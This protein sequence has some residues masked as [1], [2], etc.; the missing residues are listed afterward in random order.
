M[1]EIFDDWPEKYDRWFETPIGS[2]VKRYEREL[3]L[4][5][6]QPG[7]GEKIMD[8]GCG[9]GIFTLDILT[10]GARVTGLD[11][12]F[13]ML[14]R[15]GSKLGTYPFQMAQGDLRGLP[16]AGNSF[17]KTVSVTAIEFIEDARN[18]VI[19]LFRVTKPGGRIVVASLNSKSPWAVR[20]T[21]AA[22]KG[23]SIFKH[24]RFW[25]PEEMGALMPV[26][27]HTRTAIHFLK[28]DDPVLA[29]T[30]EEEGQARGL[31]TGAFLI[32]YWKKPLD[33]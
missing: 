9:T 13:P 12:S 10:A 14:R 32:M 11:L 28:D 5:M 4:E 16:F 2:L 30:V 26:E 6:L 33:G 18:A 27:C 31:D 15:A 3:I 19:E 17:D 7:P 22:G 21:A 23:H 24:A 1:T 25:S 29:R 8:A 20:R